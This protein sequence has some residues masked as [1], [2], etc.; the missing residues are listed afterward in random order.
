MTIVRSRS[1]RR[2]PPPPSASTHRAG[3]LDQVTT[4]VLDVG[5]RR[6]RIAVDGR[7]GAGA[8]RFGDELAERLHRHGRQIL[9]AGL[10]EFTR[11]R[12]DADPGD[13][14]D[15]RGGVDTDGV[16]RHLLLPC[17]PDGPGVCALS[18]TPAGRAEET[19]TADEDAILVVDGA[20]ALR[21]EFNDHWDHRFWLET[22]AATDT[23]PAT[24]RYLVEVDPISLADTVID[25]TDP[26][27]PEFLDWPGRRPAADD[28]PL[29][30]L[31]GGLG[32]IDL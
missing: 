21:P 7:A 20:F 30:T 15:H 8:T 28:D 6:L 32:R 11:H 9:R 1:A 24:R 2:R 25:N 16:L 27:A 10:D 5:P 29:S 26:A 4:R 23:D 17:A 19:V 13:D 3:L 12:D 22:D 31:F 18:L 14:P